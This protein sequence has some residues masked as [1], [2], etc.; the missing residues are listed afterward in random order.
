MLGEQ[1]SLSV[2]ED[3][4]LRKIRSLKRE[5]VRG[6][7]GKLHGEQLYNLHT[8][9]SIWVINLSRVRRVGHVAH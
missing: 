7:R 6:C 9:T 2:F 5:E 3:G 8:S 1:Q 4:V